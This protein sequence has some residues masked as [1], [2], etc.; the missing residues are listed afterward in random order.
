MD[1]GGAAA[2]YFAPPAGVSHETTLE[3]KVAMSDSVLGFIK[4]SL[5]GLSNFFP[6]DLNDIW[7]RRRFAEWNGTRSGEALQLKNANEAEDYL[8]GF[9]SPD[10][11]RFWSE[12]Y[13]AAVSGLLPSLSSNN[14]QVWNIG[15]GKGYETFSFACILK[16]R[17]PDANLKIWANDNDIMAISQAP[18]LVFDFEEAPEYCRPYIV[19]G[20]AGY[21]FKQV[22]KDA[23][24]FEYHD[25]LNDNPLPDLDIVLARDI[26]SFLSVQDQGRMIE[27]FR[28]KLKSKGLVFIG[29]NEFLPGA[30]WEFIGRE[31]VSVFV[32]NE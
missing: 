13:A 20:R 25:I 32:L 14:V 24:V 16:S 10:T 28:E 27:G 21:S 1:S 30:S 29:R 4:E 2:A 18:N 11:G 7:V 8:S 9:L 17:Y 3:Q 15:C 31:P 26:L 23:I 12:D 5:P 6:S 19:K 22:I